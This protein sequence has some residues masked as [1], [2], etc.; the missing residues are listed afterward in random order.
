VNEIPQEQLRMAALDLAV[1]YLNE[2][3]QHTMHPVQF[4]EELLAFI[5]GE[6]K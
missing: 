6:K 1:K 2:H 5:T 4:A 3:T